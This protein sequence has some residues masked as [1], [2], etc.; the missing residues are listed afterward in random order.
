IRRL[1]L[2]GDLTLSLDKDKR[3]LL[4]RCNKGS[5]SESG[6]KSA[7]LSVSDAALPLTYRLPLPDFAKSAVKAFELTYSVPRR[8]LSFEWNGRVLVVCPISD[9]ASEFP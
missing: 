9:G 5:L 3:A 6:R 4:F 8:E 1:G 7:A 2:T